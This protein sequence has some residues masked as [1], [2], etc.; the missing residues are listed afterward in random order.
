MVHGFVIY[1]N[2]G[3]EIGN[4]QFPQFNPLNFDGKTIERS[5]QVKIPPMPNA[6]EHGFNDLYKY[7]I[8]MLDQ[9]NIASNS[10]LIEVKENFPEQ[11]AEIIEN[12][13]YLIGNYIIQQI[14]P[15]KSQNDRDNILNIKQRY[16]DMLK[17]CQTMETEIFNKF[18]MYNEKF[19]Q[20][21][22]K[23]NAIEGLVFKMPNGTT[24]KLTGS[25]G[26]LNQILNLTRY[27]R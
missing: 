24:C 4:V 25:F 8:E 11:F 10:Q 18:K 22:G 21:G 16:T 26:P 13:T 1:N 23:F 7:C 2:Q 6:W 5:P 17:N 9:L 14:A 15:I 19:I 3:M 27:K 20:S 12:F